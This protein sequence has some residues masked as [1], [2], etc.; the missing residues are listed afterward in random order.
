VTSYSQTPPLLKKED[1][2]ER[3]KWSCAP[4]GPE[5]KIYSAGED[6][7]TSDELADR[8]IDPEAKKRRTLLISL[9]GCSYPFLF[10][11]Y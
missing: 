1:P 7:Q 9:H 3:K 11:T 5:N 2:F 6:Q 4:T 8:P 10:L